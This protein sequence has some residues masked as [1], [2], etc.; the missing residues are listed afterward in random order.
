M[1]IWT[2]LRLHN[3]TVVSDKIEFN[4]GGT[5]SLIQYHSSFLFLSSKKNISMLE[6]GKNLKPQLIFRSQGR[7]HN[8][9][10]RHYLNL[11]HGLKNMKRFVNTKFFVYSV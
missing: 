8:S 2:D 6:F 10:A 3:N 11:R 7:D 9:V 1:S 5:C 4:K